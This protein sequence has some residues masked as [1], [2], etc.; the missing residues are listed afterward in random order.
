M[1]ISI[2]RII[3]I[4]GLALLST[5]SFAEC[6]KYGCMWNASNGQGGTLMGTGPGVFGK[7]PALKAALADCQKEVQSLGDPSFR[8]SANP[9]GCG[10]REIRTDMNCI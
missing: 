9:G 2:K 1:K 10:V 4:T 7:Q 5:N 6:I 3:F 8:C